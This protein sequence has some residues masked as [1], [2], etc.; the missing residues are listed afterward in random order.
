[1]ATEVYL[2]ITLLAIGIV[3]FLMRLD[4]AMRQ[5]FK[6]RGKMLITCPENLKTAA[7]KVATPRAGLRAFFGRQRLDL[8]DCSRWPERKDCGQDCICQVVDDPESH[9][10]WTI[11][12]QWY[13]GKK[14]AYCGKPFEALSHADRRPALRDPHGNTIEWDDLPAELLLEALEECQPVC[15]SCHIAQSFRREHPELVVDRAW[16]RGALGEYVPKNL[17]E[18]QKPHLPN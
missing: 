9:R 2:F 13:A 4:E 12:S 6:Y 5:M 3:Y 15:W 1:M 18:P 14:C 8:S 17:N 11:A 10:V 16:K 7:I